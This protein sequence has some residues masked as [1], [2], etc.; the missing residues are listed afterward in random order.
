M[1]NRETT[2]L[3]VGC[4]SRRR[5]CLQE[6][7]WRKNRSRKDTPLYLIDFQLKKSLKTVI[8]FIPLT[9]RFYLLFIHLRSG[10]S[11][12]LLS[13][14]HLIRFVLFWNFK[15]KST[16]CLQCLFGIGSR[17]HR[18]SP[19]GRGMWNYLPAYCARVGFTNR[20]ICTVL[21]ETFFLGQWFFSARFT[22]RYSPR[23]I[24]WFIFYICSLGFFTNLKA[25]CILNNSQLNY[26]PRL[27]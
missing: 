18:L 15:E 13:L 24:V 3:Q 11:L 25:G 7:R 26:K 22:C 2:C 4:G 19:C 10:F 6:L 8:L 21:F 16:G 20:W 9:V 5:T 1:S 12:V 23:Q 14:F 27:H 17:A